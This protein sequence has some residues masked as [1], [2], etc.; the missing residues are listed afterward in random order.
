MIAA[1]KWVQANVAR[2]GGDPANVTVFG[3]SAGAMA[4]AD[5]IA[6]PLAKGISSAHR[7]KK[8]ETKI[9]KNERRKIR[10]E[11]EIVVINRKNRG[12]E[13]ERPLTK[14]LSKV[15]PHGPPCGAR[16]R[17]IGHIFLRPHLG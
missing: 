11:S 7:S 4:I 2:F 1:L 15:R 17:D 3:E 9:R 10:P 5:L 14:W 6:S 13:T 8:T 16:V 12:N